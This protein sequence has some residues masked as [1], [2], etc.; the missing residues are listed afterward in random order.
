MDE[1][2]VDTL[3]A[4]L[5][6]FLQLLPRLDKRRGLVDL[7]GSILKSL[8]GTATIAD[9]SLHGTLN[10]LEAREAVIS[11]S[12]NSQISY[13]KGI[14]LG[15]RTNSDAI[16]NLSNVVKTEF[17]QL[18][19]RYMK[20]ASDAW[21]FNVTFMDYSSLVG[22]IRQIEFSL[23]QMIV[24]LDE[25]NMAVQ[26]VLTGKLPI[27]ILK[28]NVLHGILR[29]VSLII[30]ESYELAAGIKLED[31]HEYYDLISTSMVGNAHG[32][33]LI[34]EIP[35][36]STNQI[37]SLYR[38]ITL[39]TKVFDDIFAVYNLEYQFLGWTYNQRDYDRMTESD[40][41]TCKVGHITI[42]PA[43]TAILDAQ[44]LTCESELYFQRATKE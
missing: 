30:P 29:N 37:F 11:H 39:P 44:T 2:S 36:K 32:L 23:L 16:A 24:Q 3:E 40:I 41:R 1:T 17:I 34:L 43:D 10:E 28:P 25:L 13:V 42:C 35:L 15:S 26:T 33:C 6:E 12:L 31:I 18:Y 9:H 7:G 21:Q 8:F 20:L 4:R 22:L 19:N 38:I 14:A 5:Q 27:A